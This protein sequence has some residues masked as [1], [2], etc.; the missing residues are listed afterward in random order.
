MKR[1]TLPGLLLSP[2]PLLLR[3]SAL[4][5]AFLVLLPLVLAPLLCLLLLSEHPL[6]PKDT[7]LAL[8]ASHSG[9]VLDILP[10]FFCREIE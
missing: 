6:F 8:L 5:T 7:S 1:T 3:L 10:R 9:F 2:Q 4:E